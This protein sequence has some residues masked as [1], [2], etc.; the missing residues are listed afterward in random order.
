MRC[1][2]ID[3]V[4]TFVFFTIPAA[5]P[6]LFIAGIAPYEVLITRL[7][8]IPMMVITTWSYRIWRGF[9][10]KVVI[11][12]TTRCSKAAVDSLGL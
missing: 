3:T 1:L 6:E 7:N 5:S 10:F 12:P 2:I 9:M 8:M 11:T 4:A